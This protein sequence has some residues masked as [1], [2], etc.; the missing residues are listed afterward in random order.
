VIKYVESCTIMWDKLKTDIE[1]TFQLGSIRY[2]ELKGLITFLE[3]SLT[4]PKA[5]VK[6]EEIKEPSINRE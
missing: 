6:F 2:N 5:G 3:N 4:P 1:S